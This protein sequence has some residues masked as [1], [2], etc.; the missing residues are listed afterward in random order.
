MGCG[1]ERSVVL[2]GRF[3]GVRHSQPCIEAP[4][5]AATHVAVLS[6]ASTK[7]ATAVSR[8]ANGDPSAI[9]CV[10]LLRPAYLYACAA[11]GAGEAGRAA[12]RR[13]MQQ[14]VL[15]P[16]SREAKRPPEFQR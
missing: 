6:R 9:R 8:A 1:L 10:R 5:N 13:V 3:V 15:Q 2:E 11:A 16:S 12:D 14:L 7:I 4:R